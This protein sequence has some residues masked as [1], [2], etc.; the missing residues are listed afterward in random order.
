MKKLTSLTLLLGL[1]LCQP[2]LAKERG[3]IHYENQ[4]FYSFRL[5]PEFK[6]TPL[7][8]DSKTGTHFLDLKLKNGSEEGVAVL[9]MEDAVKPG[10]VINKDAEQK[11]VTRVLQNMFKDVGRLRS[12]PDPVKINTRRFWKVVLYNKDHPGGLL[13][14]TAHIF[15]HPKRRSLYIV[16]TREKPDSKYRGLFQKTTESFRIR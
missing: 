7:A 6:V 14:A 12:G 11:I 3:K 5:Y 13:Y 1:I 9:V 16:M 10:A 4:L 8:T 2:I 15:V